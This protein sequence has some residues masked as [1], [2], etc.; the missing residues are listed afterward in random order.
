MRKEGTERNKSPPEDILTS[1]VLVE[2]VGKKLPKKKFVD[3]YGLWS[4]FGKVGEPIWVFENL[5]KLQ[6]ETRNWT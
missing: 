1:R 4:D 6:M 2:L 5:I 3:W